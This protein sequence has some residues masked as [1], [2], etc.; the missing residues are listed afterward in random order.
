MEGE[1]W[2]KEEQVQG[3]AREDRK[4]GGREMKKRGGK[5]K[6]K[7][8]RKETGVTARGVQESGR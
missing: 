5:A 6:M 1:G 4:G 2:R 3:E 7:E 8:E